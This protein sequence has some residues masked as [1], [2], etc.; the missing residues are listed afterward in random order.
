MWVVVTLLILFSPREIPRS[1]FPSLNAIC[2]AFFIYFRDCSCISWV[3][4]SL[5]YPKKGGIFLT[6]KHTASSSLAKRCEMFSRCCFR[7]WTLLA[8]VRFMMSRADFCISIC[9]S[10]NLKP[11]D[12]VVVMDHTELE[13]MWAKLSRRAIV[14]EFNQPD[15]VH[16][17]FN[18]L[19]MHFFAFPSMHAPQY[20]VI[21]TVLP[22]LQPHANPLRID[23]WISFLPLFELAF[24][25]HNLGACSC[26]RLCLSIHVSTNL[27]SFSR[28]VRLYWIFFL[29]PCSKAPVLTLNQI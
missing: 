22:V 6:R 4:R 27:S 1:I 24:F 17:R 18:L 29:S 14:V 23:T 7:Q 28:Q 3:S 13:S 19:F 15:F 11:E 26:N 20:T 12:Y 5:C 16:I 21:H 8:G 25:L 10:S 2:G 9:Y